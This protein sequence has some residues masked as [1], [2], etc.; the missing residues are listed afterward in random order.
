MN[1]IDLLFLFVALVGASCQR[2]TA[3]DPAPATT[4]S[5]AYYYPPLTG[6]AWET[7]TPEALGWN[8]ANF[9]EFVAYAGSTNTTALIVLYKGRIVTERYWNG[10]TA[11]TTAPIFS[12]TKT[13]SG[14][15]AGIA[16][17]Q[18]LLTLDQKVSDL[19]GAGWSKAPPAKENAITIRHLLTMTS[20]LDDNLNYVSDAGTAW[21]YNNATYYKL[22][23]ALKAAYKAPSFDAFTGEVLW[24][25][26]GMQH[27]VWLV[28]AG[29]IEL[30]MSCSGRDMARFGLL[31]LSDGIWNGSAIIGN[32][33]STG[34]SSPYL[35]AQTNTSQPH[36][37][38]Y[39]YLTW[40]NGK[41]SYQL[42]SLSAAAVRTTPGAL[43]PEAPADLVAALGANDKKIYWVKSRDLVVIRHG[44]TSGSGTLSLSVYDNQLWAKLMAAVK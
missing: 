25:K 39:G 34:S 11:T 23:Y 32:G 29:Q 27:S 1:R 20:G 40:L 10:W 16:Q 37:L 36:N 18:K 7:T 28:D 15:M 3:T 17:E 44:P 33:S 24:R 19:L 6:T 43:I 9:N 42:P 41:A 21:Y 38:A 13:M 2:K 35:T 22:V 4:P 14:L 31:M 8:V 30:T 12:A 26:I 5:T